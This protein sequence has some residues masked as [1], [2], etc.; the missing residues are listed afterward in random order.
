MSDFLLKSSILFELKDTDFS[1]ESI[2]EISLDNSSLINTKLV[3][4]VTEETNFFRDV[5]FLQLFEESMHISHTQP[6]LSIIHWSSWPF[7]L[8][9]L[10]TLI[11]INCYP[12]IFM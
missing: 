11:I 8:F 6:C 9:R 7:Y 1:K 12:F 4:S 3:S 5:R 10:A 2:F